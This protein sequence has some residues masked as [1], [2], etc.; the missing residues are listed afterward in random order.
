M[1]TQIEICRH[2]WDIES[3]SGQYS[4]GTC[5]NCGDQ[6]TF[7][8]SYGREEEAE[9]PKP[10]VPV[11][12]HFTEDTSLKTD[13]DELPDLDSTE[14]QWPIVQ[15]YLRKRQLDTASTLV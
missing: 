7:S 1:T 4:Q 6:K 13:D 11:D 15:A 10:H 12:D 8:N 9:S 5:R 3:P 14:A 2:F